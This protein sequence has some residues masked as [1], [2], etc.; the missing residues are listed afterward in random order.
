M[1]NNRFL[2]QYRRDMQ[3][4]IMRRKQNDYFEDVIRDFQN[5]YKDYCV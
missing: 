4:I 1:L 3:N 5:I 2:K